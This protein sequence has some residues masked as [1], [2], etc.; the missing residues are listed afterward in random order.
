MR[1]V[2][3]YEPKKDKKGACANSPFRF[4]LSGIRYVPF[5]AK[6]RPFMSR[7]PVKHVFCKCFLN[8][9]SDW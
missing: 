2:Q 4:H 8:I 6:N 9:V 1:V 3:K 5:W 7:L